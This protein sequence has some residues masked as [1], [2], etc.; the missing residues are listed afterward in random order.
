MTAIVSFTDDSKY[1]YFA[2]LVKWAWEKIGHDSHFLIPN[3]S[4]NN[5]IWE[6][7]YKYTQPQFYSYFNS[8]IEKEVTYSQVG[9]LYISSEFGES[10]DVLICS[11]ADM[12]PI[13]KQFFD[14]IA[15]GNINIAGYDLVPDG[16]YPM[17]YC[18]MT[19]SD[20]IRTMNIGSHSFQEMLDKE[21]GELQSI[22][23]RGDFW[24]RDQWLLYKNLQ[25]VG[26]NLIPRSNGQNQFAQN[27]IDR[28][29]S[30]WEERLNH[31]IIDAHLW[32]PGYTEENFEK[33]LKLLKYFYPDEDFNWLISYT[34]EY[35]KLVG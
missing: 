34:N 24:S 18:S 27:R 6:L 15:N 2:P 22:T 14:S 17:C 21:V 10:D 28:D 9:R 12:L 35:R 1:A 31:N 8:D 19:S 23:F 5:P 26:V 33:I 13:N 30:F 4:K 11:D 3:R 25:G 7:I 16:Q 29:D 32:R 20:W